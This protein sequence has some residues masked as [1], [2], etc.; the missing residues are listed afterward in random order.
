MNVNIISVTNVIEIMK[1]IKEVTVT[2]QSVDLIS[3]AFQKVLSNRS[4][5][6]E[7]RYSGP[8]CPV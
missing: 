5:S 6:D 8:I 1:K 7:Y 4:N 2:Y 3:K